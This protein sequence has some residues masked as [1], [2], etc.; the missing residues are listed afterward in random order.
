MNPNNGAV[1]FLLRFF[2]KPFQVTGFGGVGYIIR[3]V[4]LVMEK[5]KSALKYFLKD[6]LF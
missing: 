4:L 5:I 6:S 3:I 1:G 2:A